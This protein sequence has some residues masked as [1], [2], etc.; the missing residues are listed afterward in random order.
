[1]NL[2]NKKDNFINNYSV[3]SLCLIILISFINNFKFGGGISY[4]FPL[5]IVYIFYMLL[6]KNRLKFDFVHIIFIIWW[7]IVC[8]STMFSNLT[9]IKQ[10][11]ISFLISI[12]FVILV[13]ASKFSSKQIKFIIIAY[14]L[15]TI[16]SSIN[17]IYNMFINHQAT[18]NRYSTSF[19]NVDKDPNYASAFILPGIYILLFL[20]LRTSKK[21]QFFMIISQLMFLMILTVAVLAT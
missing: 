12:I 2:I 5:M 11:I 6:K 21:Q 16:L 17:I 4:I 3:L 14:L 15:A 10:D 13:T 9:I 7:L 8:I 18:W 19:F 1:M 20:I